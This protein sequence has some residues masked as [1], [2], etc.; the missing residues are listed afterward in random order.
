MAINTVIEDIKDILRVAGIGIFPADGDAVT[1]DAW[2][3]SF[4]YEPD[5]PD[6]IIGL[7]ETPGFIAKFKN[8]D[9]HLFHSAFQVRVRGRDFDETKTKADAIEAALDRKGSFY[10][11][12]LQYKNI[13]M[14]GEHQPL[15]QDTQNRHIRI[16]NFI[17][18][19]QQV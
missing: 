19:R 3:I 11:V 5:A 2:V 16:Q 7:W 4:N 18:A 8:I 10:T 14:D 12:N 1:D 13:F 15:P 6:R 9:K 17:A